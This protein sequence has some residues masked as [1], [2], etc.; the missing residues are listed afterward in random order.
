MMI[1]TGMHGRA[2]KLVIITFIV[3]GQRCVLYD[4][5]CHIHSFIFST[6]PVGLGVIFAD[7]THFVS[8]I[9]RAKCHQKLWLMR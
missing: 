1:I 9:I 7:R 3:R 8:V 6:Y 2:H 5:S 4:M